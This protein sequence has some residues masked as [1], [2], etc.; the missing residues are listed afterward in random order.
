MPP[1]L[2]RSGLGLALQAALMLLLDLFAEAR[3]GIY[4]AWLMTQGMRPVIPS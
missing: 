1:G 2:A 3:G 4:L